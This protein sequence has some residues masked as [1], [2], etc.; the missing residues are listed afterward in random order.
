MWID[1]EHRLKCCFHEMDSMEKEKRYLGNLYLSILR[2]GHPCFR[3]PWIYKSNFQNQAQIS[4]GLRRLGVLHAR[5]KKGQYK[6]S[7]AME[8]GASIVFTQG[9]NGKILV[10]IYPYKS[11]LA[12]TDEDNIIIGFDLEPYKITEERINK[13]FSIFFKYCAATSA[14]SV[15]STSLYVFRIW[16]L[17]L[18]FRNRQIQKRKILAILEKILIIVSPFLAIL[19]TLYTSSKWPMWK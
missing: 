2:E 12:K 9:I 8:T 19:A 3:K 4:T 5:N 13:Y 16:L 7:E 11:S 1:F 10:I 15:G 18:D 17:L 6:V 14:I